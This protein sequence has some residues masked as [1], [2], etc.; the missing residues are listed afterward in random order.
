MVRRAES[1]F[2]KQQFADS[3]I[4]WGIGT[5]CTLIAWLVLMY[6]VGSDGPSNSKEV[7]GCFI[8][9]PLIFLF[10]LYNFIRPPQIIIGPEG[11][12]VKAL[13]FGGSKTW[14][15]TLDFRSK[16]P[17]IG[18]GV[19]QFDF[20]DEYGVMLA[21]NLSYHFGQPPAELAKIL[22]AY[23]H[24]ALGQKRGLVR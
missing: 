9:G 7:F 24:Q 12:T 14:A 2:V 23:R 15:E 17:L 13:A 5:L 1:V 18:K 10:I 22:N 16:K 21:T 20:V 8:G 3:R 4:G 11:F 19:V 6:L